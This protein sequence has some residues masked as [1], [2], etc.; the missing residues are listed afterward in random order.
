[1]KTAKRPMN[2]AS[3]PIS[4]PDFDTGQTAVLLEY[5]EGYLMPASSCISD[6]IFTLAANATGKPNTH[7]WPIVGTLYEPPP[8]EKIKKGKP[9]KRV[10]TEPIP[11]EK[12]NK[13]PK[14]K[15]KK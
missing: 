9:I 10:K 4:S 7:K 1:M 11:P 13:K 5:K 8:P 2:K 3:E 14:K 15:K 6:F 12:I